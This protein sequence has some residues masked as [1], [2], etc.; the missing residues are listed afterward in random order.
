MAENPSFSSHLLD[1]QSDTWTT[2]PGRLQYTY[3]FRLLFHS[4]QCHIVYIQHLT[5]EV[6]PSSFCSL[7]VTDRFP[8]HFF[9]F[10]CT[11][12]KLPSNWHISKPLRR[13]KRH[14]PRKKKKKL[15]S[16]RPFHT[17]WISGPSGIFSV[18]TCKNP[19]AS[20]VCH[21]QLH[22]QPSWPTGI[23]VSTHRYSAQ[24]AC[25]FLRNSGH[26]SICRLHTSPCN[27]SHDNPSIQSYACTV[28][29]TKC[30]A[31]HEAHKA[32]SHYKDNHVPVKSRS[33]VLNC[34]TQAVSAPVMTSWHGAGAGAGR[35]PVFITLHRI[36]SLSGGVPSTVRSSFWYTDTVDRVFSFF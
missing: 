4:F 29:V 15:H 11:S 10:V 7:F 21:I 6:H 35:G 13:N 14:E 18:P 3:L 24:F 34:T 9:K 36:T 17:W 31:T 12:Y 22:Q 16:N 20:P 25:W 32:D 19:Y 2:D 33:H 30:T 28:S 1:A 27:R 23:S 8:S 26:W 5:S